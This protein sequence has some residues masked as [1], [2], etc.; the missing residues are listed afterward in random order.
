MAEKVINKR[1]LSRH[2]FAQ[3]IDWLT[4]EHDKS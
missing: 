1:T 4:D 3:K 2:S